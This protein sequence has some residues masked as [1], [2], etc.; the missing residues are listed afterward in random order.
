[1]GYITGQKRTCDA[2]EIPTTSHHQRGPFPSSLY[3]AAYFLTFLEVN[4]SPNTYP[5]R[6]PSTTTCKGRSKS[7]MKDG[8]LAPM[9]NVYGV[10]S[11]MAHH[12]LLPG[13][14]GTRA[15][16]PE[17]KKKRTSLVKHNFYQRCSG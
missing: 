15:P 8:S 2:V 14:D 3:G 7:N 13:A 6:G 9:Q 1:M 16:T 12:K 10:P 5:S 4:L 11:G 17:A